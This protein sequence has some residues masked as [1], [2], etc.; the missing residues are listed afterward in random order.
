MTM[1]TVLAA[2]VVAFVAGPAEQAGAP[3]PP[4]S[5]VVAR[6][7]D[8]SVSSEELKDAI[9]EAR[10]SGEAKR[11]VETLTPDG[12]ERMALGI[13]ERKVL[14]AAGRGA[15]VDRQAAVQRALAEAA[16]TVLAKAYVDREVAALDASEAGLRRY[17]DAHQADF[18]IAPR[19]K[20]HHI[21]VKTPDE[22]KAA[23]ADLDAG[24]R[25]EDVARARN[26]DE[27]KASGGDLGW[28][29]RGVMVKAFD[30]ALFGLARPGQVSGIVATSFGV[31]VIRLDEAD[32]GRLP[33]FSAVREQVQQAIVNEVRARIKADLASRY[34]VTVDRNALV[35]VDR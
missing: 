19:R 14:A 28:V 11:M 2:C 23:L 7:G 35:R 34:P 20:A 17:F 8:V 29:R 24:K 30:E 33:A 25:F 12:V 15:G 1:L 21:V 3:A 10:R 32:P 26:I 18:R 9:L 27:T 5:H 22:A 6:A 4:S 13:L 16:D 31:H